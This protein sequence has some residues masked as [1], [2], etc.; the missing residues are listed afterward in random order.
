MNA[1]VGGGRHV[2]DRVEQGD[3][4]GETDEEAMEEKETRSEVILLTALSRTTRIRAVPVFARKRMTAK[5]RG[6]GDAR[7]FV[8]CSCSRDEALIGKQLRAAGRGRGGLRVTDLTQCFSL[9]LFLL[10]L[11]LLCVFDCPLKVMRISYN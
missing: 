11:L 2:S 7:A 4:G 1:A 5:T 10:W 3:G 8:F 9:H 6:R